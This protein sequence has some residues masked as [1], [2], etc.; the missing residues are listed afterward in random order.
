MLVAAVGNA[1][2]AVI[3]KELE[4]NIN[5]QNIALTVSLFERYL[6]TRQSVITSRVLEVSAL[7]VESHLRCR[8]RLSKFL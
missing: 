8:D 3:A 4:S 5:A 2:Q 7:K 6:K 1:P